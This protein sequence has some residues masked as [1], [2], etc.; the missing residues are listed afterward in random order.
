MHIG[1]TISFAASLSST[2]A[3]IWRLSART[4]YRKKRAKCAVGPYCRKIRNDHNY[5][6]QV[7]TH[8]NEQTGSNFTH[9][10]RPECS[11]ILLVQTKK[12]GLIAAADR[13]LVDLTLLA[14]RAPAWRL[15][16][17]EGDCAIRG[18][19]QGN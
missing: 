17:Y 5:G 18:E 6:Q 4:L 14:V 12:S 10:I 7:E 2:R 15:F 3:R 1:F 11:K 13:R 19:L 16:L 9:G 8:I